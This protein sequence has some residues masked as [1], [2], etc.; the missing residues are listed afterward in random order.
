MPVD[1][2][3]GAQWGDEGKGKI[4]DVFAS[5]GEYVAGARYNG[6]CNAGHTIV[7]GEQVFKLHHLPS[8]LV[9]G[10]P[11]FIGAGVV[12]LPEVFIR[13]LDDLEH[14][15]G[16]VK[17]DLLTIDQRTH[18][19]TSYARLMD[20]V[21]GG[22]VGTTGRGIGPTYSDHSDRVGIR[23]EDLFTK[24]TTL[25]DK[26]KTVLEYKEG[27]F[28]QHQV[29]YLD[30][31]SETRH[32]REFGERIQPY[33]GDAALKVNSF[34]SKGDSVLG[35][36]GQGF[37][38]D[39][40][41][42]TYPF[43][44]SSSVVAGSI[45][46]GL[47]VPPQAIRDVIGVAKAYVTRVGNGPFPTELTDDD[48]LKQEVLEF[49]LEKEGMAKSRFEKLSAV[50]QAKVRAKHVGSYQLSESELKVLEC[51]ALKNYNHILGKQIMIDGQEYGTTTGRP[52]RIGQPHFGMLSY[53][54]MVSGITRWAIT[55]IDVLDGKDFDIAIEQE[56]PNGYVPFDANGKPKDIV[57]L[58]DR[59]RIHG[60]HPKKLPEVIEAG[61]EK[62]P[63]TMKNYLG[64]L[65]KVTHVPVGIVSV[66]PDREHTIVKEV[67][68]A[69]R[70]LI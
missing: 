64:N 31:F 68:N 58:P 34:L 25:L 61:W 63:E 62:L 40:N 28:R 17:S 20:Q 23:V 44:T 65:T 48:L 8:T 30:P 67:Y 51:P 50:E 55:K 57:Y 14:K 37:F 60:I 59:M 66:G 53:A 47:G 43:C 42:G 10:K 26:V 21:K 41:F 3:M 54:A 11:S 7:V 49:I 56:T 39:T 4:I 12:I 45:C 6:G 33:V 5:S 2:V 36:A 52:R 1:I 38:L 69:T 24:D 29:S 35:E 18:V 27:I 13:E 19:T 16:E 22:K 15:L 32:L 46:T 70:A 9:V